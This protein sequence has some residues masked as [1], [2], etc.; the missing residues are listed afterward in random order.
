MRVKYLQPCAGRRW[1]GFSSPILTLSRFWLW[2]KLT[3]TASMNPHRGAQAKG[4]GGVFTD[5]RL[6]IASVVPDYGMF[7]RAQAPTASKAVHTSV[8]EKNSN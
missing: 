4:R 7:D 1:S 6:R 5:Y 3:N 2:D 8:A